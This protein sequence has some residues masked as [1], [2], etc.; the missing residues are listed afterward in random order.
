MKLIEMAIYQFF[1][2]DA[3]R[4]LGRVVWIFE[5]PMMSEEHLVVSII[6]QNLVGFDAVILVICKFQ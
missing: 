3:V 6:V 5:P 2:M 4:Y 1:K